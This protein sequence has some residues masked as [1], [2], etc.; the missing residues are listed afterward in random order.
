MPYTHPANSLTQQ[1]VTCV[2][3]THPQTAN[4]DRKSYNSPHPPQ[5]LPLEKTGLDYVMDSARVS[6]KSITMEKCRAALGALGLQGSMPMAK[7]G[8]LSGGEKARVALAAFALVPCNV[9]LLDEASN[10]LD[11][12]TINVLTGEERIFN[13]PSRTAT[14]QALGLPHNQQKRVPGKT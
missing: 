9:L 13:G 14:T 8:V 10:H 4:Y 12:Q 5:D 3:N 2:Y 7:I 1:P 11:A 6:D